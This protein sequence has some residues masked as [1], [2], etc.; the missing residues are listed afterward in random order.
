M[1]AY[2]ERERD[3]YWIVERRVDGGPEGTI[4]LYDLE[5]NPRR[6][7]WG[8]W[9]LRKGSLAAMESVWL[10]YRA[11]FEELGMSYVYALTLVGNVQVLSFHDSCGLV[12]TGLIPGAFTVRG[13]VTDAVEHR[14]AAD[15]WPRVCRL[16]TPKVERLARKIM[17]ADCA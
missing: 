6:A 7:L 15:E 9:I 14:L 5:E 3:W 17:G 13:E 1:R 12:R 2:E 8:R 16:L 11:A 10:L 4:S